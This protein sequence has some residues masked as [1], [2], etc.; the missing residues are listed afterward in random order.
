MNDEKKLSDDEM[1]DIA[2]GVKNFNSSKSNTSKISGDGTKDVTKGELDAG[3]RLDSG[4]K[5]K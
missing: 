4:G 1:K 2:G 5:G 3:A